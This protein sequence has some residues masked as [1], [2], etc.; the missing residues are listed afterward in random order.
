[1]LGGRPKRVIVERGGAP[2]RRWARNADTEGRPVHVVEVIR[3]TADAVTLVIE[4]VDGKPLPFR[5]GQYLTHCFVAGGAPLKRAYSLSAREGGQ[6]ACTV[7]LIAGG[8]A[9]EYVARVLQPGARYAVL[10]PT[11]DFTLDPAQRGALA[12]LAAGSGITPVISL[13]ETALAADPQRAIRLVYASRNEPAIIFRKRLDALAAQ[14]P[15]LRVTHVLSQPDATWAGERGRLDGA[16]A[17]RLLG[18]DPSAHYYLCG[19]EALMSGATE[20]LIAAG[21]PATQ[22]RRERFLASARATQERPHTAQQIFFKRS[23]VTAEQRIGE[24]ILEAGL[25]QG[26]SLSFSCTVGGCASCKVKVEQ[27]DVALGEPNCLTAEE[28]AQGYTLACSAF[29]LNPVVIDA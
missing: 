11:G 1:M 5:A 29:A 21:I 10:G 2:S 6:L 8:G 7:K 18:T 25:R 3:E 27:G 28:R 26:V 16:R 9:S 23:G 12:L 17:A 20:G 22:I 24:S 14:H 19:P 15:G 13:I 4:A